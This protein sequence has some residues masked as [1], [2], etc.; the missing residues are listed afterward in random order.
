MATITTRAGKGSPLTNTEVDD[1][2]SNLNSAKYE[3]DSAAEF[4]SVD[5]PDDGKIKLG[6]DDDLQIY[7]DGDHSIIE[8]AGN[9]AIKTKVGDFRVENAS[10]NNLIKGVGDV[11]TLHHAGSQVLATTSTGIDVTGTVVAD[12]ITASGAIKNTDGL[13]QLDKGTSKVRQ[14]EISKGSGAKTYLLGRIN[15]SG[16]SVNGGVT[17]VVKAAYDQG[18]NTTNVNVH[19]AFGH[20]NGVAK[21]HWWYENTDD[22][23]GTDVVSVKLIDDGSGNYYVWVYAGDFANCFVE[24]VWRQVSDS[25]ITDSGGLV[26]STITSGTTLFDTEN[27]PTSEHHIGKLYAHNNVSVAGAVVATGTITAN[28]G[29]LVDNLTIDANAINVSSGDLTLDSAGDIVL[30]ADGGHTKLKDAG[31]HFASLSKTSANELVVKSEINNADMLF[32]GSDNLNLVTALTLDMADAGSALFN[33]NVTVTGRTTSELDLEAIAQSKSV[34]ATNVFVYDTSKDSDG[35]AWRKRTQGTSWYNETLNTNTRGSRKEFPSVAVIVAESNKVTIYDGDDPDLPMWMVF[36]RTSWNTGIVIAFDGAQSLFALNGM[37]VVGDK[38]SSSGGITRIRFIEDYGQLLSGSGWGYTFEKILI[39]GRN[40]QT[41]NVY[42]PYTPDPQLLVGYKVNDVA[43]TVLPNAPID[44]DTG[45]PVPTIAVAT[46]GGVSVIKDDGS[47]VDITGHFEVP[48]DVHFNGDKELVATG[49]Y[50]QMINVY[51]IPTADITTANFKRRYS[52]QEKPQID[53][54]NDTAYRTNDIVSEDNT[55]YLAR[56]KGL[57]AIDENKS[58]KTS[59]LVSFIDSDYNTGWMV[60]DTKLATLSDTDTADVTG[61]DLATGYTTVGNWTKQPSISISE[62]SGTLSISGNG[63]GSNVYFWLPLTV[64]AN[65]EYVLDIT[66]NPGYMGGLVVNTNPYT[67]AGSLVTINNYTGGY[68]FNS[69]SNT[70]VKVQG[71]QTSS[72]TTQITSMTLRKAEE[73]R[74]VNGNGLQ[75]FGTVTKSAVAT[76]ADLVLYSGFSSTNYF[77]QPYSS[78]LDFPAGSSFSILFWNNPTT[79]G[80]SSILY[81]GDNNLA[82]QN[83]SAGINIWTY[84]GQLKCQIAGA[85]IYANASTSAMQNRWAQCHFVCRA[86][87]GRWYIDGIPQSTTGTV[88]AIS[89]GD[90]FVGEGFYSNTYT[91]LALLRISATAPSAEQIAKMYNDEKPLFQEGAQATLY[92]TSDA[93]TALAY[94]DDTELLHV[95]TSAGRSV[96]QGLRRV[97]NTT[98]AVGAAISASNGLV[99]E[100]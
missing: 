75:V 55:L 40:T 18:D 15:A 7:H 94:D 62:S 99:A 73:D 38:A 45:L 95:G 83:P 36:N 85:G 24:T 63:T 89:A 91:R 41:S 30:D 22:D 48:S 51:D 31:V 98:D 52:Y 80:D 28:A 54:P 49:T 56:Q 1:N 16:N 64:E 57:V 2:F 10:G 26:H 14:Y 47:V 39:S 53:I 33:N 71:Y 9:G 17:G 60:G 4:A 76:G 58:N 19:F 96:F 35:G 88:G 12:N 97:D 81:R 34:T 8:D 3:S 27:D 46:N 59:S 87:I 6:N 61:S 78:D 90:L 37:L 44:A 77:R 66:I 42:A 70:S 43:M 13:L 100:D 65:T 21:G 93:V 67:L 82:T 32:Q 74:S 20:R 69:G 50:D 5:L 25:F 23:A 68:T 29:V 84:G 79:T 92:G 86:G 72:G 11:A